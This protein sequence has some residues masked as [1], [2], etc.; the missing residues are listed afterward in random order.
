MIHLVIKDDSEVVYANT[1]QFKAQHFCLLLVK[2]Y[3][4]L[5]FKMIHCPQG[6]LDKSFVDEIRKAFKF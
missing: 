5:S 2:K 4:R 6:T 1:D 3:P